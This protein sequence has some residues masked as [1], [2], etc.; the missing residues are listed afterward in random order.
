[1]KKENRE[2]RTEK[3][4]RN[5]EPERTAGC[6]R[7]EQHD[8]LQDR[9][10]STPARV[11]DRPADPAP[12][13]ALD[14]HARGPPF[15]LSLPRLLSLDFAF[16]LRQSCR[17]SPSSW[18]TCPALLTRQHLPRAEASPVQSRPIE[19][20]ICAVR[21]ALCAGVGERGEPCRGRGGG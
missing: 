12:A 11:T 3:G 6:G 2:E 9:T 15:S 10:V 18:T 19:D 7:L 5:G 20:V 1:M 8:R 4:R 17:A 21:E 13:E 14:S 16:Q